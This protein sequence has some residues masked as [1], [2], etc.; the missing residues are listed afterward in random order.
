MCCVVPKRICISPWV[1]DWSCDGYFTNQ[2]Y[3]YYLSSSIESVWSL[4]VMPVVVIIV[5]HAR[6]RKTLESSD[7]KDR[8]RRCK[9]RI[10][11][12][13]LYTQIKDFVLWNRLGW[14]FLFGKRWRLQQYVLWKQRL[15]EKWNFSIFKNFLFLLVFFYIVSRVPRLP[16]RVSVVSHRHVSPHNTQVHVKSDFIAVI[17]NT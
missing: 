12:S 15:F 16:A 4:D 7:K 11:S 17:H 1:L 3:Y 10:L 2:D 14:L 5:T 13:Y 9:I 8:A 6:Y